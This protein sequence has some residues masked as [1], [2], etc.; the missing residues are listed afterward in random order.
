MLVA[1]AETNTILVYCYRSS[2]TQNTV[3][4]ICNKQLQGNLILRVTHIQYTH[5]RDNT[6]ASAVSSSSVASR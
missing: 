2:L 5:L 4:Y 3:G 6:E 1:T